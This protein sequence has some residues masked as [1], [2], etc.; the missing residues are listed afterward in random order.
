MKYRSNAGSWAHGRRALL[1][2]VLR[3]QPSYYTFARRLTNTILQ[4]LINPEVL[5]DSYRFS[6]SGQYFAPPKGSKDDYIDFI[7]SLPLAQSPEVSLA[8]L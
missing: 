8:P 6:E 1:T 7:K 3:N 2:C 5:N 4:D